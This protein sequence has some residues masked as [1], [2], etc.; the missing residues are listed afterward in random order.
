VPQSHYVD[1]T[2]LSPTTGSLPISAYVVSA[3][4]A[5]ISA[6]LA[7]WPPSP[8]PAPDPDRPSPAPAA[9]PATVVT[10]AMTSTGAPLALYSSRR[11]WDDDRAFI[12]IDC[13][14][15]P[16]TLISSGLF[17]RDRRTDLDPQL[18]GRQSV[19]Y[20]AR[21][22]VGPVGVEG[23]APRVRYPP[24]MDRQG[25]V[26]IC[27]S[28]CYC[29]DK[30]PVCISTAGRDAEK[31]VPRPERAVLLEETKVDRFH[32]GREGCASFACCEGLDCLLYR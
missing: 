3:P 11:I 6:M 2:G 10:P 4:C 9:E 7:S 12:L 1:C 15:L 24:D 22:G 13:A 28:G 31:G 17:S 5:S 23:L 30:L 25:R 14:S 20:P 26:G 16:S 32:S 29:P 19:F 8:A 21:A 18:G 27:Q